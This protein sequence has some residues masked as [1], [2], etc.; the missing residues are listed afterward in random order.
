MSTDG[1]GDGKETHKRQYADFDTIDEE[2]SLLL[3][4]SIIRTY[5]LV[6]P[7]YELSASKIR[8]IG[9]PACR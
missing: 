2:Y 7:V 5:M 6:V 4:D 9:G 3:K 8:T 1:E